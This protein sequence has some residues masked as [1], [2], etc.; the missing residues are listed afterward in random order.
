M[1][2]SKS[3]LEWK[4]KAEVESNARRVLPA[5]ARAYF[6]AGRRAVAHDRE[7]AA[8]H[9]FRLETKRFRYTVELFGKLYGPS[10]ADWLAKLK[11]VQDALGQVNDCVTAREALK[12]EAVFA[13][14]LDRRAERKARA[15]RRTWKRQ[16]DADGEEERWVRYLSQPGEGDLGET[17]AAIDRQRLAGDEVRG[18]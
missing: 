7:P 15:F 14:F 16:F 4:R 5:A 10:M 3:G 18:A 11:P 2:K 1:G 13:A 8:L 6:A 12:N 9:P 17:E